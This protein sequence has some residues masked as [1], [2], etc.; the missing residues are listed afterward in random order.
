[1][2]I[3]SILS[4]FNFPCLSEHICRARSITL[5]YS[6]HIFRYPPGVGW[7][8]CIFLVYPISYNDVDYGLLK[9]TQIIFSSSSSTSVEQ[10]SDSGQFQS[11]ICFTS[12]ECITNDVTT[13]AKNGFCHRP[14][15]FSLSLS[16]QI[17]KTV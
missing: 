16:L 9:L 7:R 12:R 13:C 2:S 5:I 17:D 8:L 10:C 3:L 14:N 6:A 15:A 1:M 4:I 11:Q